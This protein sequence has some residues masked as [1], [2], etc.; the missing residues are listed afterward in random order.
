MH[1]GNFMRFIGDS[2]ELLFFNLRH[3]AEKDSAEIFELKFGE[4]IP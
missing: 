4:D 3:S 2:E 1:V